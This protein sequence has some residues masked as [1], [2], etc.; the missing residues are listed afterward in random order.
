MPD[1]QDKYENEKCVRI[2]VHTDKNGKDHI[3]F[4]DKDP[5]DDNHRSIHINYD[6]NTGKGNIVDTTSGEKETTDIGCYLI[7]AC[8][9]HYL[10]FHVEATEHSCLI[11][12]YIYDNIVDFCVA[13]IENGDYTSAYNRYRNSILSLEDVFARK[14]LQARLV[15]TLKTATVN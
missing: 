15:K 8:M 11:Y 12:D 6:S 3:S 7:S 14:H 2:D 10:T 1:K 9:R 13:A 4:Y 5:K